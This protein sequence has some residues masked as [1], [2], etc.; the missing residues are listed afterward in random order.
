MITYQDSFDKMIKSD[1]DNLYVENAGQIYEIRKLAADIYQVST[2]DTELVCETGEVRRIVGFYDSIKKSITF[3][4]EENEVEGL[5]EK[6]AGIKGKDDSVTLDDGTTYFFEKDKGKSYKITV[7][8]TGV[9][10]LDEKQA[11]KLGEE[12][13][14][15]LSA[16]EGE[17]SFPHWC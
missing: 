3:S 16:A 10:Y 9:N 14:E 8:D 13:E 17:A 7:L 15:A 4:D 5:L 1:V 2:V 12:F 11:E 6:A